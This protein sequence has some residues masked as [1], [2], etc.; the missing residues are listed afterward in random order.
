MH[1]NFAI[2]ILDL[3]KTYKGKSS[4]TLNG[5]TLNIPYASLFGLLAPNGAG[6]TTTLGAICGLRQFESG[7]IYVD[8]FSVKKEMKQIKSIIGFVPQDIALFPTLSALENLRIIGGIY[9][10]PKNQLNSKID[11][12]LT[13]FDLLESKN[14]YISQFSGGMKRRINLIAGMMHNPKILI[15]DEPTVGVDAQSRKLILEKLVEINY[16]GTTILFISHYLAEAQE[17]CDQVAFIDQGRVIC[18][19]KPMELISNDSAC[20]N[21]ETLYISLTGKHMRDYN[22]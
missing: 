4:P 12:L 19:G 16:K 13:L 18:Q 9:G 10:L 17:I 15:L 8:G 2:E 14:S 1:K 3:V 5:L 7:S 21:L 11:E 22:G 6:K 20:D